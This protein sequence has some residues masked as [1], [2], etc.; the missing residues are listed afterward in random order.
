[1]LVGA[2]SSPFVPVGA[3]TFRSRLGEI[4]TLA[5]VA[6]YLK[7]SKK[8]VDRMVRFGDLPAFKAGKHWRVMRAELGKWIAFQSVQGGEQAK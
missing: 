4:L 7:I 3:P 1:M 6:E 8:T 5:E 2:R